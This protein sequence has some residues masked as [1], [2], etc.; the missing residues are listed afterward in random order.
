MTTLRDRKK[1]RTRQAIIDA[2]TELF[3]E[4]GYERTTIAQIAAAAD[5]GTRTFF[6]YFATKEELL[7][8]QADNRV[9]AALDAIAKRR[10]NDSPAEVLLRAV[11]DAA[12]A[13]NDMVSPLAA[14]RMELIQ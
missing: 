13:D 8:S 2:A 7:F 5:I 1:L 6:S 14:L 3:T 4:H 10:P 11:R 12:A 9:G